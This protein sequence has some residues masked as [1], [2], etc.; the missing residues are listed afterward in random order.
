MKTYTYL[1]LMFLLSFCTLAQTVKRSKVVSKGTITGM[2]Y[3]PNVGMAITHGDGYVGFPA[4]NGQE[5]DKET[6]NPIS[7]DFPFLDG[8]QDATSD[9]NG[10]WFI[11]KGGTFYKVDEYVFPANK[12]TEILHLKADYS[13]ITANETNIFMLS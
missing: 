7:V 5:V 12:Y 8:F 1:L 4:L 6:G 2:A 13:R 11:V 9:D 3:H 10:G